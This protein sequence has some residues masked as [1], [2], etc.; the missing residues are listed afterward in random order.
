LIVCEGGGGG[1]GGGGGSSEEMK[2][3]EE[4]EEDEGT[5][6]NFVVLHRWTDRA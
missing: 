6:C 2:G 4:G 3:W 1:V 5:S